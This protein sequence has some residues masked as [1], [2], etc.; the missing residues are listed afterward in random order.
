M[1][2]ILVSACLLGEKVRWN[3]EG[4]PVGDARLTRWLAEGRIVPFCPELAAGLPVPRPAVEIEPGRSAADV[5]AGRGR[6]RDADGGD[7]S[8]AFRDGAE[9]AAEVAGA[10]EIGFALLAEGSPSCGTGF[11]ADGRFAGRR[12]PGRG[13]AAERLA[14]AGVACFSPDAIE[15]LAAALARAEETDLDDARSPSDGECPHLSGDV[16]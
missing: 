1:R 6:V 15:A 4:R 5:L 9:R 16:G 10:E 8:A 11:V 13:L 3:G 2:K 12:V 7:F 14:E